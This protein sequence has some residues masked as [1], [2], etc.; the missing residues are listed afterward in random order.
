LG[1]GNIDADFLQEANVGFELEV[2]SATRK[3]DGENHD[4]IV[5]DYR[6]YDRR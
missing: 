4:I 5:R 1:V 6:A 3:A 2:T